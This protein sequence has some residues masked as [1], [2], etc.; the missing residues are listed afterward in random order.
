MANSH[1]TLIKNGHVVDPSQGI[2][3]KRDI[4]IENGKISGNFRVILKQI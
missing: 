2:D 3:K 4:L 1:K